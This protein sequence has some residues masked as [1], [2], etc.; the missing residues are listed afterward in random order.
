[1]LSFKTSYRSKPTVPGRAQK[2]SPMSHGPKKGPKKTPF[3]KNGSMCSI[4]DPP[5]FPIK[6]LNLLR[7]SIPQKNCTD[8]PPPPSR[9]IPSL[10]LFHSVF[11]LWGVQTDPMADRSQHVSPESR[12]SSRDASPEPESKRHK[13]EPEPEPEPGNV[14][15]L[16]LKNGLFNTKLLK[17]TPNLAQ[18]VN[19]GGKT[20]GGIAKKMEEKYSC[21]KLRHHGG[22]KPALLGKVRIDITPELTE[23]HGPV[24]IYSIYGQL[25]GGGSGEEPDSAADRKAY[26]EQGLDY[27]K[28]QVPGLKSIAFPEGIGCGI[29]GGHWPT[30]KK[31]IHKFAR[32]MPSCSVYIVSLAK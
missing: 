2:Q 6:P 8:G 22:P 30:Y 17:F 20:P 28:T 15:P 23:N 29:G 31:M 11:R 26:F 27:I 32:D 13:P 3:L 4:L 19:T 12:D 18:Q 9:V 25:N 16:T 5:N 21:T 1:M 10:T 24:T 7:T 14:V